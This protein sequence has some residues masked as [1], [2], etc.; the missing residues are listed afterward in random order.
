MNL[1]QCFYMYVVFLHYNTSG[2][3][4]YSSIKMLSTT[5]NSPAVVSNPQNADMT[6]H[7]QPKPATK[8]LLNKEI[9][10]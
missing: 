6:S 9:K 7:W 2:W 4:G 1:Q 8:I 5:E 10:V 3:C